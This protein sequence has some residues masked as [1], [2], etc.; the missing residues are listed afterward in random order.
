MVA[1]RR[2]EIEPYADLL[3]RDYR[4][5]FLPED[6]GDIPGGAWDVGQDSTGTA[7]FFGAPEVSRITVD[8]QWY[9]PVADT[10]LGR[11][12]QRVKVSY[13]DLKVDIDGGAT[14]LQVLGDRQLLY[15]I[16]GRA[17]L[18]EDPEVLGSPEDILRHAR[19]ESSN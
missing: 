4:F 8:L 13:T 2:R 15:F 17:N 5:H 6:S 18:G 1:Y 19:S 10:L 11:P 3:A 16:Q 14:T 7:H 9:P 12:V